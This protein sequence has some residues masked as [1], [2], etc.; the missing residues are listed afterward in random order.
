MN[1]H[2]KYNNTTITKKYSME[3]LDFLYPNYMLE[4]YR[5]LNIICMRLKTANAK[6]V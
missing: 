2:W 1:V 5:L 4:F 3:I 6:Y